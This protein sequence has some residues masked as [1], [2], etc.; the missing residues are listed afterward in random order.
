MVAQSA[1]ILFFGFDFVL[2]QA[3][4]AIYIKIIYN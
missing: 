3:T 2:A 1:T 4:T